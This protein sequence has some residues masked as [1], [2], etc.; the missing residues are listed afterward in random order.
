V[1]TIAIVNQK[2][3]CGKTTTA[4]SLSSIYAKRGLRTLLIDLDPQAHCAV[5]L[6]VPEARVEYSIADALL[7]D[8]S[9]PIAPATM[10][11][12]VARGLALIPS[13]VRLAG[14][15]APHGGLHGMPDKDRRLEFLLRRLAPQYDRCLIDCPPTI[16]LLTFNALRAARE[17]IIPVETGFFALTGAEKQWT[18]IQRL[19]ERIDRPIAVHMLATIYR[20][21]LRVAQEILAALRRRFA[22]QLLPV[23]IRDHDELREATSFGQPIT[24]YSPQSEAC[25]DFQQLA[26]WLEDHPVKQIAEIELIPTGSP[27]RSIGPTPGVCLGSAV[28]ISPTCLSSSGAGS[29]SGLGNRAAELARRVRELTRKESD[30]A[31]WTTHPTPSRE[32]EDIFAISTDTPDPAAT[33]I[34][35][36]SMP[37]MPLMDPA[38]S[39]LPPSRDTGGQG[40]SSSPEP[41]MR[42][43]EATSES[44]PV[45]CVLSPVPRASLLR[46]VEVMPRSLPSAAERLKGI[47]GV[48]VTA[49]GILFVQPGDAGRCLA[50]AG[51]FNNWSATLTPLR[52]N[53]GLGVHETMV[54]I[55][56]GRY[57]YRLV[58][59]G[60]WQ[61]DPYNDVRVLNEYGELNSVVVV[62]EIRQGQE[63]EELGA[64]ERV[65]ADSAPTTL[66]MTAGTGDLP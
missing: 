26:D 53:D 9:R 51:D 60:R 30:S 50:V 44:E 25:R 36:Q 40:H 11:W 17:T 54:Q 47:F 22:G 21:N 38:M 7:A 34:S 48:R 3:G 64:G 58:V 29:G 59:D 19:I 10:V 20:P 33:P 27:A 42:A 12:E 49:Q 62:G 43:R 61:A 35:G 45:A 4:I 6:G 31:G 52:F 63:R 5:G 28:S 55:P 66:L 41:H 8:P 39:S 24:E 57:Q 1:R 46:I 56:A 2:G 65:R 37:L 16:G 23:I 18:T 13:T 32:G 14:L 15:E